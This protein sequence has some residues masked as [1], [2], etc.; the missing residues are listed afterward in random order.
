MISM[1][2]VGADSRIWTNSLQ[3]YR[4]TC[5]RCSNFQI[6]ELIAEVYRVGKQYRLMFGDV[7]EISNV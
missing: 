3:D 1:V 2:G 4:S 7:S 5:L 6:Q